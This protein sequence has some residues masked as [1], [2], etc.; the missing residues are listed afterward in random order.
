MIMWT[1]SFETR[2]GGPTR[3]GTGSGLKKLRKDKTRGDQATQSKTRLQPVDFCS[4]YWNDV[5]LI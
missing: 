1:D 3:A 4:F 5:V 2:P